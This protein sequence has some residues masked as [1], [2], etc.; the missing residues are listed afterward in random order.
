MRVISFAWTT[1]ALLAGMKTVTRREWNDSY[2]RQFEAGD[3][4]AAYDRSPRYGG[5]QVATLRLLCAPYQENI[6]DAPEED[7]V[8][9][10]LEWMNARGLRANRM[11]PNLFWSAWRRSRAVVWVVRFELVEVS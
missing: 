2:A 1:P 8:A 6:A 9:E 5:R 4:V 7:Y 10:G 11:P 3:L